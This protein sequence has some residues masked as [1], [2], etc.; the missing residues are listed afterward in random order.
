MSITKNTKTDVFFEF[1]AF[2]NS[3]K[4]NVYCNGFLNG[5]EADKKF[6]INIAEESFENAIKKLYEIKKYLEDV[7]N[8]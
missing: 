8:E 7:K 6:A 2:I 1:D 3:I 5:I 4:V